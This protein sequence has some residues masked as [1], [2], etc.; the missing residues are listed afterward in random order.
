ADGPPRARVAPPPTG[1]P[2]RLKQLRYSP[3]P[4]CWPRRQ[5]APHARWARWRGRLPRRFARRLR[6]PA[7]RVQTVIGSLELFYL[8]RM[9]HMGRKGLTTNAGTCPPPDVTLARPVALRRVR[10]PARRPRKT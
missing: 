3:P 6:G 10:N 1:P 9:A 7:M 4:G 8:V 5:S 2:G